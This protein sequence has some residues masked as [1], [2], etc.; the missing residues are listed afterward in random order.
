MKKLLVVAA[1]LAVAAVPAAPAF[2]AGMAAP[3]KLAASCLLMPLTP[4]CM[5]EWK[6]ANEDMMMKVS[7]APKMAMMTK[8]AMATPMMDMPM[9]MPSCTKAPAGSGHMFDCK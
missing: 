7:E 6:M 3:V 8:P 4:D 5:A 2:A 1:L 9:M